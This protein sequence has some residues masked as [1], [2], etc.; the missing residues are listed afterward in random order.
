MH[1][2][3]RIKGNRSRYLEAEKS[4]INVTR[5]QNRCREKDHNLQAVS[6]NIFKIAIKCCKFK[7]SKFQQIKSLKCTVLKLTYL[8]VCAT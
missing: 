5:S 3:S 8:P 1:V 7:S 2:F 6:Y 4:T